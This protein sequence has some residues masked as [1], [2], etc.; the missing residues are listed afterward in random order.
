MTA[1]LDA[2]VLLAYVAP[3][4]LNARAS[5]LMADLISSGEELIWP[6]LGPAEVT[7]GLRTLVYEGYVDHEY[8]L[9]ALERIR[10]LG[11]RLVSDP[12]HH[13]D[14]LELSRRFGTRRAYDEHYLATAMRRRA[15][16]WT[17]DSAFASRATTVFEAVHDLNRFE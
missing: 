17:A 10:R 4:D 1:C 7:S 6:P 14:A 15:D 2:S 9:A 5:A 13:A 16:L 8:A 11:I 12:G 3:H